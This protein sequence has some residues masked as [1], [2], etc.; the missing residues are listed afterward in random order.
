MGDADASD[1]NTAGVS[2]PH[3]G[4]ASSKQRGGEFCS[5]NGSGN[6][7]RGPSSLF[8]HELSEKLY[9]PTFSSKTSTLDKP[10][11]S[12]ERT[13][14]PA[15]CG[16]DSSLSNTERKRLV[17]RESWAWSGSFARLSGLQGCMCMHLAAAEPCGWSWAILSNSCRQKAGRTDFA[18][19]KRVI[20]C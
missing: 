6:F 13:C 1:S 15:S 12:E 20:Y 4:L 11:V 18:G 2:I 5:R 8:C 3:L 19:L 9:F 17:L 16:P 14:G 7:P 10:Q